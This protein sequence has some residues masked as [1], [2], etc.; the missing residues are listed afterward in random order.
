[1]THRLLMLKA[2]FGVNLAILYQHHLKQD[3]D[4]T[5]AVNWAR[6]SY[7]DV[8]LIFKEHTAARWNRYLGKILLS[9]ET[10]RAGKTH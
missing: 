9:S 1:M 5:T 2:R 7:H 3:E 8:V 4:H 6:H 10:E